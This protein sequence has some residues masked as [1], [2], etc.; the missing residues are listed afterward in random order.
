M[1]NRRKTP[2][3]R[4]AQ[5]VRNKPKSPAGL[6]AALSKRASRRLAYTDRAGFTIMGKRL[7]PLFHRGKF[8]ARSKYNPDGS[9]K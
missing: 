5:A 1:T 4:Q 3:E 8:E 7:R 2:T 6:P 9:T